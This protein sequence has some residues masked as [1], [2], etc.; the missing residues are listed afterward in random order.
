MYAF[1]RVPALPGTR[2]YA[3][4]RAP[5]RP[6][7]RM[8]AFLRVL[9]RLANIFTCIFT[10]SGVSGAAASMHFWQNVYIFTCAG[11]LWEQHACIL[12]CAGALGG[13]DV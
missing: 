13:Q 8:D 9:P 10:C 11:A 2:M 1:L 4:L 3:F 6:G 5:A 7:I 12:T